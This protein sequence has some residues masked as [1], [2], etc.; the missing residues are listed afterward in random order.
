[1]IAKKDVEIFHRVENGWLSDLGGMHQKLD[2]VYPLTKT[3]VLE[4]GVLRLQLVEDYTDM[5]V[6][7][8]IDQINRVYSIGI[9]CGKDHKMREVRNC[10]GL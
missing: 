2:G 8:I 7:E 1:M 3:V 9:S 5:Q 6:S 10:L 4:S